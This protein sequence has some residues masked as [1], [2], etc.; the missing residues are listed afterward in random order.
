MANSIITIDFDY[1][2]DPGE[3]LEIFES[4]IALHA[5][6]TFEDYRIS[7]YQ[8]SI[9]DFVPEYGIHP[10]GYIARLSTY[11]KSAFNLDY[12]A[13]NLFTVTTVNGPTNSGTGSVTITANYSGAIFSVLQNTANFTVTIE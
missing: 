5:L 7:S 13:S 1:I 8:T 10:E 11:Y 6:E 12:N 2:P 9:P 4:K 3:I